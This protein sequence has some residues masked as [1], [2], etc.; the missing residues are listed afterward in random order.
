[1][2]RLTAQMRKEF[3]SMDERIGVL[4]KEAFSNYPTSYFR[5]SGLHREELKD[6]KIQFEIL[7]SDTDDKEQSI[8]FHR[9]CLLHLMYRGPCWGYPS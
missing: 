4:Y 7:F 5:V 8:F 3:I 6:F 9:K 1:M 2:M